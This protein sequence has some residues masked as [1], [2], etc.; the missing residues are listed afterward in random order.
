MGWNN[1]LK[2]PLLITATCSFAGFDDPA[3]NTAGEA[4]ILKENGGVI[5]LFS[6]VRLVYSNQNSTLINSVFNEI[7]KKYEGKYQKLGDVLKHAKN[8]IGSK[9]NKRK[10]FLFGDPAMQ[11]ALPEYRVFTTEINDIDVTTQVFPDTLNALSKVK[12][13]GFVGNQNGDIQ[14]DF[15]GTIYPTVFDKVQLIETLGNDPGSYI[16]EFNSREARVI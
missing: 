6:T 8:N 15:N 10:F 1:E 7:F 14:A 2:L 3:I 9:D 16:R 4:A 11:L 12:V 5:A 13:K